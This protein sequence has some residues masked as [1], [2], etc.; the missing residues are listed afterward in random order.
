MFTFEDLKSAIPGLEFQT[1]D[2][3]GTQGA[4]FPRNSVLEAARA[5]K[6]K[7]GFDQIIDIV[8]ID[9]NERKERFEITY[10]LRN[11][12]TFDRV[13]I[14]VRCDE[15]DPHVPSLTPV[16]T[17]CNWNEREAYDM[18]GVL[19]DGHPDM[20]RMYLPDEFQY[21]PLRKDFPL[22]GIPGSIPLPSREGSDPRFHVMDTPESLA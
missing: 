4:I 14:K 5:L 3:N 16:W 17:G 10:N 8:G 6:E 2:I 18:Y 21:F 13:F 7:F 12:K 19:F 22:I 9:R 11:H 1:V 20:R 15:R